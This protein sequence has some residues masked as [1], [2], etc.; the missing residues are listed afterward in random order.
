MYPIS[1]IH[2]QCGQM[3]SVR[4][5]TLHLADGGFQASEFCPLTEDQQVALKK[6]QDTPAQPV[7]SQRELF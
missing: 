4:A 1:D 5:A 7:R 3:S 2:C 6:R